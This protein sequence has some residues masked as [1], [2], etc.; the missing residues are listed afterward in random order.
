MI[1]TGEYV[2]LL[3]S[4]IQGHLQDKK[5]VENTL[6][7]PFLAFKMIHFGE[8]NKSF[9]HSGVTKSTLDNALLVKSDMAA[10]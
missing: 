1:L 5:K 10:I 6:Q 8:N 2:Y 3:I 7:Y 9:H 4:V